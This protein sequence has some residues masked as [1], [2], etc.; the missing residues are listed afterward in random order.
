MSKRKA[1]TAISDLLR[2]TIAQSGKTLMAIERETGVTRGSIM[3]FLRRRQFLRLDMADRL[4]EHFGLELV[5][6]K[7]R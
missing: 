6:K 2:Q 7:N 5:V 1:P 3:R 4:A